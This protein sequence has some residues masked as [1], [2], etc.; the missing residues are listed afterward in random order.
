MKHIY[1]ICLLLFL[2][3]LTGCEKDISSEDGGGNDASTGG[4]TEEMMRNALT[5]PKA[6][7]TDGGTKVVVKG[8]IVAAA[9]NSIK[10][11]D[12]KVP[13]EGSTALVLAKTKSNGTT[14]QFY[15][16]ELIPICLTDAA[17]GLRDTYNL[18]ENNQYWNKFV[19]VSGTRK[20]Y[21]SVPGIKKV[22]AIY[23][24]NDHVPT[25]DEEADEPEPEDGS[26]EGGDE[27]P[28]EWDGETI[29]GQS[30]YTV[31]G[32]LAN[33]ALLD[34]KIWVKGYIVA[35]AKRSMGSMDFI[36]PFDSQSAI[37][38][39]DEQFSIENIESFRD[40]PEKLM[41]IVFKANFPEAKALANL[42]D[43]PENHNKLVYIFGDYTNTSVGQ[44]GISPAIAIRISKQE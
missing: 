14:D 3:L 2:T 18:E 35:S 4:I 21:M 13:F 9:E 37:I 44:R 42:Q 40:N 36:E 20:E 11:A 1:S 30:V 26:Q 38:L 6:I 29:E 10:K 24:D 32:A 34:H 33:T 17:K 28:F 43:H 22:Q 27:P 12:F 25:A 31:S 16:D 5:V 15:Y 19:Y 41:P 8:Y 23:I 39:S 7:A